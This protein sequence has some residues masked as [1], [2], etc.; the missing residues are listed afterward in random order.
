MSDKP[1]IMSASMV[2]AI[3]AGRKTETR[4]IIRKAAALDALAVFGPSMLLQP[5]CSDLLRFAAGDRLWVREAWRFINSQNEPGR[6][7]EICIG[8][9]ADG[10]SLPNRP[11]LSAPFADY[12]KSFAWEARRKRSPI[13]MPR[14]ASRITL[15]VTEVRVERLQEITNEGAIAEGIEPQPFHPGR[16]I[17][18]GDGWSY[19]SAAKAYA[20]LWDSLH[21]PGTW[22]ANPWV[23]VI[24]FVPALRNIDAPEDDRG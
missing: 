24:R 16:F 11:V 19:P 20:A 23:A 1:I 17:L 2:K 4:R 7:P 5:G 15:A 14:W 13:H 12:E 22:D 3:L 6:G 18:A 21:G 10:P 8:Y 9:E